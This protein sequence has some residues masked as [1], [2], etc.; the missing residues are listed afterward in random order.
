MIREA[1]KKLKEQQY[2]FNEH[3]IDYAGVN[4]A[5]N[6]AIR[7]LE[8]WGKVKEEISE[9]YKDFQNDDICIA[10]GINICRRIIDNHLKEVDNGHNTKQL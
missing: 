3:C 6:M 1:I 9:A 8:A 4:K 2:E 7:S 5:Y 10:N